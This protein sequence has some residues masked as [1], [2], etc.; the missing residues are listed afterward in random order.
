[1]TLRIT[2]PPAVAERLRAK[3]AREGQE[4]EQYAA[5]VLEVALNG[6]EGGEQE[7]AL[8]RAVAAMTNRTPEQIAE[9]QARA[10]AMYK[11]RR[12]LPPGKTLADVVMGQWPGNETD[13][14]IEAA[15]KELS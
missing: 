3:A 13:E 14:Q 12:E 4:P 6:H 10:I 7:S 8:D 11:P 5:A 2:L 15:L 1:M 9:A